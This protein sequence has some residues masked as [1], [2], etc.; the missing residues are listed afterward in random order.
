M[1]SKPP[2]EHKN[3]LFLQKAEYEKSSNSRAFLNGSGDPIRH[4][5]DCNDSGKDA[6]NFALLRYRTDALRPFSLSRHDQTKRPPIGG[7]L[8]GSGD[9]IRT[10]DRSGMKGRERT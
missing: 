1:L 8:F 4:P 9:P 6:E 5:F 2:N 7:L 3:G 10:D